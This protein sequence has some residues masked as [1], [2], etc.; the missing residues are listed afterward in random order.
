MTRARCGITRA[1]PAG[2]EIIVAA[3]LGQ[4]GVFRDETG[5]PSARAVGGN[6]VI[7]PDAVRAAATPKEKEEDAAG[8]K[9]SAEAQTET[10]RE[11]P[12]LCPD[13]G[14]DTPHGASNNAKAY[15]ADIHNLVNPQNP[16]PQGFG[17]S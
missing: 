15:E 1:G 5:A 4:D 12:K 6:V 11:E 10:K 9:T 17:V 16:L 2:D 8:H 3:H 14:P 13:P 7:D